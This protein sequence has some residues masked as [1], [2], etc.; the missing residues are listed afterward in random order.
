MTEPCECDGPIIWLEGDDIHEEVATDRQD[1]AGEMLYEFKL[2]PEATVLVES[3]VRATAATLSIHG[4]RSCMNPSKHLPSKPDCKCEGPSTNR[5][6]PG[7]HYDG[8]ECAGHTLYEV[9]VEADGL[10]TTFHYI[11]VGSC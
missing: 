5:R 1:S 7:S 3:V 4:R 11:P 9:W 2:E 6:A 8:Q 10:A